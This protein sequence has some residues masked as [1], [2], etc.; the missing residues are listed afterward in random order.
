[1]SFLEVF[2]YIFLGFLFFAWLVILF[3]IV[4]DLFRDKSLGGFAK[5]VWIVALVFLPFLSMFIY[6]IARGKG[7]AERQQAAMIDMK[8]QQDE[9]IKSVAGSSSA[10]QIAQ[11]KSLLDSGAISQAE[12]ESLKA[13]ALG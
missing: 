4:G 1:M 3:Q 8:N 2:W 7:M 11:A 12:F 9:Y 6:L 13:K 5:G 10:D